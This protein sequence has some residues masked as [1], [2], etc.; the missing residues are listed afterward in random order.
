MEFSHPGSV[1]LV[2]VDLNHLVRNTTVISRSSWKY[3]AEL[4]TELDP[5]MPPV[6]LAV[7]DFNQMLL[8]LIVN[9]AQAVEDAQR[10]QGRPP[11]GRIRIV[12]SHDADRVVLRIHDDGCGIPEG[13]RQR[14]YD[15]FFTTKEVGRGSGQGL[16]IAR[17]VVVE[18]HK[19]T[20]DCESVVGV[21]TTFTI[22]LPLIRPE[23]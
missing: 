9:A 4:T 23:V 1:V 18:R 16:T 7:G 11:P 13:I 10:R 17:S 3:V 6:P 14:I 22:T 15:P 20:I 2:L 12:T 5:S 8:N 21:G 19:G